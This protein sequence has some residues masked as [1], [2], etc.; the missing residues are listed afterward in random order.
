MDLRSRL[1]NAWASYCFVGLSYAAVFFAVSLSP[2]LVPRNFWA[3]GLLS[4]IALAVGYGLGVFTAWLWAY[5][6]LPL[7][8]DKTRDR[9][10]WLVTA[11]TL[12]LAVFFLWRAGAWQ[13]SIRELMEMEPVTTARPWLVTSIA[14]VLSV[15]LIGAARVL[16]WVSRWTARHVNRVVPRRVSYVVSAIVVTMLTVSLINGVLIKN[17]LRFIDA[18]SLELDEATDAGIRQPVDALASGST[19][20]LVSWDTVGRMGKNFI[21]GGLTQ[22]KLKAFWA[23]ETLKPLRIYVGFGSRETPEERAA[24]ALSELKRVGAFER[25]VLVVATPTG[26]GWLDPAAMDTL[27]YLHAGDTAIV[28]T[29]YSYVPSIVS[30]VADP[31]RSRA[32]S[33][34]LFNT[35]YAHWTVLPMDHRPK[36]YLHGL[37]LGALG[38]E[39]AAD[40]ITVLGD[41][42]QGAVWSGPP[43]PSRMWSAFTRDRV[44]G[45]P[46][47][48]PKFRDGSLVRFTGQKNSLDLPGITWGPMRIV[49]LQ[50]ASDP[51]TFFSADILYRKPDW[52]NGERGP[53]VSPHIRWYPIVTFLQVGFD[54]G[55]AAFVTKGYGHNYAPAHYINA[56][57]EVTQPKNWTADDTRRLKQIFVKK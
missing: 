47:W 31:G 36:L 6:E 27:E 7:P 45:S 13:N 49:Y 20:S 28:A 24:L 21:A 39:A 42:I 55:V 23:R 52:L 30:L 35:V 19:A 54:L 25:S 5:L 18:M 43:F 29:Q 40:L 33:L 17:A 2:S 10:K 48:L 9:I 4:G 51:T 50:Y 16:L 12:V 26:T 34:A 57:I 56:W 38:S 37:S 3:Q 53:D 22:D 32:E 44:P 46:A 8:R 1:N 11:G 15:F 41:P 14:L